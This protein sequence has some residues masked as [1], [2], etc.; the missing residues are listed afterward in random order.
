MTL[1]KMSSSDHP[2]APLPPDLHET[3]VENLFDGVYYVDRERTITYW[4]PAA[5]RITGYRAG[6]VVGRRCFDNILGHVSNCGEQLC[7]TSCP[8]VRAMAQRRGVDADVFLRHSGGHRVPVRVRCQPVRERDGRVVG[9]V[10]IFNEDGVYREA[11]SRIEDLE[12]LSSTDALTGLLNRRAAE[13]SL[14]SRQRDVQDAGWPLGL[15]FIDIDHFKQFNDTH[16]HAAGDAVLKVVA[17]SIAGVLRESDVASRWGG[18][19][20]L[21]LSAASEPAELFALAERIRAIVGASDATVDGA[22]LS[23]TVSIGAT[24][25]EPADTVATLVERA[26]RAMYTSKAE[27]RDRTSLA[28]VG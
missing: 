11:L 18:E 12:Q 8:L 15:L 13:T 14:R 25:A 10:E 21:I 6:D 22:R 9:A 5:E 2:A 19:E 1:L 4:N 16:G 26:D 24:L 28:T 23:V 7:L 3:I 20:F 17:R 27:G